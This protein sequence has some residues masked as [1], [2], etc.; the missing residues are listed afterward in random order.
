M[1]AIKPDGT[2]IDMELKSRRDGIV[3]IE[4]A[5]YKGRFWLTLQDLLHLHEWD[6]ALK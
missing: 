1:L 2:R 3:Y 4:Q 5:Y 6:T